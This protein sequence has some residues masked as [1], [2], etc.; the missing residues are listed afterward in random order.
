MTPARFRQIEEIFHAA[1][2][3]T[4]EARAAF[5][6]KACINDEAFR[7]EVEELLRFDEE[8][9]GF[10][11]TSAADIALKLIEGTG[12]DLVIGQVIGHYRLLNRL[13]AGGMGEVYLASDVIAG[14]K[15]ALKFLP[16]RFSYNS[17]RLRRFQ[18]EARAVA[19]L[20]H[21]NIVTAYEVS[22]F[23]STYFIASELIEGETL[24][25]RLTRGAMNSGEALEVAIQIT[26][27]LAAAH[28]AGIIHRDIKPEN[29]MLRPDGYVKVLDF[30]IAK[31]VERPETI[32]PDTAL[33]LSE[34]SVEPIMGTLAYMSPEQ[35]RGKPVDQRSDLWSLGVVLYEMVA[36]CAPFTG[37]MRGN[38]VTS[39]LETKPPALTGVN[40]QISPGFQ[41]LVNKALTKDREKR[42]QTAEEFLEA[43][44]ALR[45]DLE[46]QAEL[47]R[48]SAPSSGSRW[49]RPVI[50]AALLLVSAIVTLRL[51]YLHREATT[52]S[53]PEKSIAVL[54]FENI[55]QNKD[56]ADFAAGIQDDVLTSLAQIRNL[57]VI[58][59]ASVMNYKKLGR[60]DIREIGRQLGVTNVLEGTVRR[61]G[62]KV[63]VDVR[64][65]DA[66]DDRHIWAQRY[67]RAVADMIGLQG[68]LAT[69]IAVAL[70]ATLVPEDKGHLAAGMTANSDAYVLYLTARGKEHVDSR[71]A[72]RTYLQ[73]TA[74]DPNFAL[75]YA[76]ASLMNTWRSSY[77]EYPALNAKARAQAE[78]A[79]RL[80]PNLGEAHEALGLHFYW[81]E[82]NY[83]EALKE[84]AMAAANSPN[85]S[86]VYNYVAGI[87][88]RQGRWRESL[89]SYASALSLDPRDAELAGDAGNAHLFVRDWVG[90]AACYKRGLEVAPD[91]IGLKAQLATLEVFRN[92]SPEAGRKILE[93][94]STDLD[95][96]GQ[97]ALE[98]WDLS[99]L[100]R[101]YAGADK[102]L[103]ELP[104]RKLF[105]NIA[106]KSYYLGRTALAGGNRELAR[107][108]FAMT[109]P[110]LEKWVR[111]SPQDAQRHALLGLLYAY[112]QRKEEAIRE[113]R[114]A[115][116]IAPETRDAFHGAM[117]AA[118]LAQIYALLGEQEQA[119]TLV[120]RLLHTPGPFPGPGVD[121]PSDI[122][123]ADLRM[124]W[125]WDSL[126]GNAR[127]QK[128][129]AGPEP[130]TV[131]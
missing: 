7:R 28:R 88:R 54:P 127:F 129:L 126:R 59:R 97:V 104:E 1:R 123:L 3:L 100:D 72:E 55:G 25:Q 66:R 4:S 92:N 80:A 15:A 31:L 23:D 77:G 11:E 67:D 81:G 6:E 108:Y 118:N 38:V 110:A 60:R 90:A 61:T 128:L 73:A 87:Y 34:T 131:Y 85:N 36:G 125:E 14:R 24:R 105:S 119:I 101:D 71:V 2:K 43:L 58:S 91:E 106:T 35:A 32:G 22:E 39:I 93:T 9:G 51:S 16:R 57:K 113:G 68:E 44:K 122:T 65:I 41:P 75:A 117:F 109:A 56:N 124:R 99:M 19:G 12:P 37:E 10:I 50:V 29:I 63:L 102:I 46:I 26:T 103:R 98:L 8:A 111:G 70:K 107:H 120:E 83:D 95:S 49:M 20:N 69:E 82:R 76:R 96:D 27:A 121:S 30:G 18:R 53:F 94:I 5:L 33:L 78:E 45:R 86:E 21:P 64:L 130:K 48:S 74:I 52:D 116:E 40:P 62:N 89:E 112:M 84:F 114:R 79:L 115:L 42:F 13:G 47:V 17:E